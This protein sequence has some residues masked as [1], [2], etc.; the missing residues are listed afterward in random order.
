MS[1]IIRVKN[2]SGSTDTWAGV[3]LADQ[4]YHTIEDIDIHTW[5]GDPDVFSA[6][7]DGQLVVNKGADG[8]DDIS[9]VIEAWKWLTGDIL[10]RTDLDGI[11][12][13]VHSSPKPFV[14][15]GRSYAIWTG[16]GD[17]IGGNGIGEGPLL[18]FDCA[19]GTPETTIEVRFLPNE[20][21]VWI[22][23]GYLKFTDAGI[24]DHVSATVMGEATPL[25]QAANLD[26]IIE[27]NWIKY[28]PG[29]PG[30]GTHGFGGTPVIVPRTFSKDGDWDYDAVQQTLL[31][32]ATQ[33]GNAK[34]SDIE[35]TVHRYINKIPCYGTCS[36]YFTMSSDETTELPAGY[37]LKI[38]A[39][40]VSDTNWN[41]SVI[42]EI[43]R[44][45]TVDP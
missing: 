4:E 43:Y 10:P 40:N 38:T 45:R 3:E 25:Q 31:P 13:S 39:Y 35:R 34:L 6:I 44:E 37:Y 18:H 32:N 5:T 11:K 22:H 2:D 28:A 7:G 26:L 42:M 9:D 41:A 21:R 24:G 1:R 27:D 29:G 19:T 16:A 14:P 20:G 8:T 33:T 15:G 17:D 23:E 30:T 12:L 36:N